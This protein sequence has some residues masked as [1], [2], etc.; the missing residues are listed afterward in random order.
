MHS[1]PS[2]QKIQSLLHGY[3]S[4]RQKYRSSRLNNSSLVAAL[5]LIGSTVLSPL[6][7]AIDYSNPYLRHGARH[8]H[9]AYGGHMWFRPHISG[10][11]RIVIDL[12]DQMAYFYKGRR[13]AGM[14]PVSTGKAGYR[15]P[16]GNFRISE[17]KYSHRSNLYGHYI[18]RRGY[19]M[20]SNV[21]VRRHRKPRGS[22]FRGASM[23]YMMRINGP[24]TMHAGRVPGYP[25]SHGC[26]RLPWHMAKV[27]YRHARVGTRVSV[28]H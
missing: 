8:A 23:D 14:S 15:T 21:D 19:V 25:D 9:S 4:L 11:S 17:K 18:S 7:A 2:L 28:V 10:A 16:T 26:I 5:L 6:V 12:S 20:R 22:V 24:V 1:Q 27:F 13:L 3:R